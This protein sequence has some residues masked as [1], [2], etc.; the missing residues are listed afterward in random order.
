MSNRNRRAA[1]CKTKK[2]IF[3]VSD[4]RVGRTF[5]LAAAGDRRFL[6]HRA[7]SGI[8]DSLADMS[9][10]IATTISIGGEYVHAVLPGEKS[11][12][13]GRRAGGAS[14][15]PHFRVNRR[16][17]GARLYGRCD[18]KFRHAPKTHARGPRSA[19]WA[20]AIRPPSGVD[21]TP[22]SSSGGHAAQKRRRNSPRAPKVKNRQ[23]PRRAHASCP[24][25]RRASAPNSANPG[26]S[27]DRRAGGFGRGFGE[28]PCGRARTGKDRGLCVYLLQECFRN[29]DQP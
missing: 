14:C 8:E 21:G 23:R 24:L 9:N 26:T 13:S 4:F 3:H 22:D 17:E 18:S 12:D 29:Q 6:G 28:H 5:P 19:S 27:R 20:R 16:C 7:P 25:V 11:S 15:R 2:R 1:S 10:S